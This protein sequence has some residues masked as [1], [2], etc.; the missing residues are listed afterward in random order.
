M[1]CTVHGSPKTAKVLLDHGADPNAGEKPGMLLQNAVQN[2]H[3]DVAK[4]LREAG[5]K[6]VSDLA[7]QL[8][9]GEADKVGPLLNS[10]PRFDDNPEFWS[11]VL[12]TAARYGHLE[13][14]R[15]A[16][17]R[18]V[19]LAATPEDNAFTAAAGEG[20]HEA[21]SELLAHRKKPHD[22]VELQ[23]ALW[24]AVWNSNPYKQQRPAEAFERCVKML[25][26][27][28]ARAGEADD[29]GP[30]VVTAV[31]TRNPGGNPK[32]VEMLAAAGADPNPLLGGGD[33]DKPRHLADMI[34]TACTEQGCS[35]PFVRTIAAVEKAAKIVIKH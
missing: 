5:A 23:Q 3:K 21:L 4:I 7:F 24:H 35:T 25:L 12:P 30:L 26:E 18:G 16:L 22:P 1:V 20:Q 10:A 6:G 27:A 29:R 8:A 31:F 19:P 32:V 9:M 2:G 34:Q 13:A 11:Q 33:Q 28:G 17:V 14:I 15:V